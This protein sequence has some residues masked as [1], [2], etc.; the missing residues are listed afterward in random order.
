MNSGLS[1]IR[2]LHTYVMHRMFY[3]ERYC[4]IVTWVPPKDIVNNLK[5]LKS[6]LHEK[7]N[8]KADDRVYELIRKTQ[9]VYTYRVSQK[10]GYD[11]NRPFL[12]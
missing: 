11:Q 2:S 5:N 3:F 8:L 6:C 4:I 10:D 1:K 12:Q 7:Q 9:I